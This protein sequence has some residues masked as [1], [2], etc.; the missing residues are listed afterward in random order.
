MKSLLESPR[1]IKPTPET[2]ARELL[3]RRQ[4][5]RDL[6]SFTTYTKQDYRTNWHHRLLASYLDR[7]AAGELKRLMVF[8]PPQTGKSELVSRR[9]PAFLLGRNPDL[10]ILGCSHTASLAETMNLDVQRIMD[11]EGYRRLF[12]GVV[13]PRA[14]ERI[15]GGRERRKRDFFEVIGHRGYLLSAGVGNAIAGRGADIGIADDLLGK[16]E[17]A[18]SPTMR[19]RVWDW[20]TKDFTSRLSSGAPI[21]LTHTRWHQDDPAGRLLRQMTEGDGEK[22]EV[23]CLPAIKTDKDTHPDDLREEGEALWPEHK[24][25][26]ELAVLRLQDPSGFDA[27][28]QQNPRAPGNVEWPGDYFDGIF[29]DTLPDQP[30]RFH[31]QALDPSMGRNAKSGDYPALLDIYVDHKLHLWVDDSLMR[32][33]PV[34]QVEDMAVEFMRQKNPHGLIVEVNGFQQLVAANIIRK[35]EM[36]GILAPIYQRDSTEN[37]EVR[38]RMALSPLLGQ[39]RIHFRKTPANTII[40]RQLEEFPV[41]DHDDGPDALTTA[42]YLINYLLAGKKDTGPM[43][44]RVR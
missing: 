21:L 4:A 10:R 43:M 16:W 36:A 7:L 42:T 9:L 37:K 28:Y 41:G 8:Q 20:W 26:D 23:L 44:L 5:R 15:A 12:P 18:I 3:T 38:I 11:A 24:T 39:R 30:Y 17:D 32:V 25:A 19:Q 13:L 2:A 29:Y 34:D 27:L 31:V 35:A 40:V 14:G 33:M 22:W 1:A 6:L